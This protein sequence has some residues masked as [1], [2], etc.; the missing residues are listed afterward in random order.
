MATV[1]FGGHSWEPDAPVSLYVDDD[2]PDG[3]EGWIDEVD[4][5]V[6]EFGVVEAGIR[7]F[8][9]CLRGQATPILTAEHARHTLDITLKAYES[10]VDGQSHAL[11]TTF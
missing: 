6:D 3:L 7:H 9:D 5:P 11:E 10:I 8:V 1:S 2:G 4:A